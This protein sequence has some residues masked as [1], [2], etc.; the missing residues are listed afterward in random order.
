LNILLVVFIFLEHSLST[1]FLWFQGTTFSALSANHGFSTQIRILISLLVASKILAMLINVGSEQVRE[2]IVNTRVDRRWVSIFPKALMKEDFTKWEEF[3]A[4]I[5][6][7]LP[8]REQLRVSLIFESATVTSLLLISFA[9]VALKGSLT[10]LFALVTLALLTL[11]GHASFDRKISEVNSRIETQRNLVSTWLDGLKQGYRELSKILSTQG[12]NWLPDWFK[13]H[14]SPM[15]ALRERRTKIALRKELFTQATLEWPFVFLMAL[16]LIQ[17]SKGT[18]TIAETVVALGILHYAIRIAQTLKRIQEIKFEETTL[19]RRLDSLLDGFTLSSRSREATVAQQIDTSSA[20][21]SFSFDLRDGTKTSIHLDPG[22]HFVSGYNGSGKSTLIETLA[23]FRRDFDDWDRNQVHGLTIRVSRWID[24]DSTWFDEWGGFAGQVL[25]GNEV[26]KCS[27]D[28]IEIYRRLNKVLSQ[29]LSL[30]WLAVFDQLSNEI[31]IR[32]KRCNWWLSSGERVLMSCLRMLC[33]LDDKVELIF[34]DEVD[35]PLDSKNR[36]LL[37]ESLIELSSR[38]SI[39]YISHNGP[40]TMPPWGVRPIRQTQASLIAL[41]H[42]E[43]ITEGVVI[44]CE[45]H[46]RPGTG[47]VSSIG[48]IADQLVPTFKRVLK[49]CVT[50][51]ADWGALAHFDFELVC[52]RPGSR[53][54]QPES[55]GLAFSIALANV[56]RSHR[57]MPPIANITGTGWVRSNGKIDRVKGQQLKSAACRVLY[58]EMQV[59]LPEDVGSLT[60]IEA[61][62]SERAS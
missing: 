6:Q 46:F 15:S 31:S 38:F 62:L 27:S 22:L 29:R 25:L 59:L 20:G 40:V 32:R 16:I 54:G 5:T 58:P 24:R 7:D 4:A 55:A 43:L 60:N 14:T 23:C 52:S 35:A 13:R 3:K 53:V 12:P 30:R 61:V 51:K 41:A 36:S 1:L 47:K 26:S 44:P 8:R 19:S 50:T 34:A 56:I 9:C 21:R 45:V 37:G 48:N 18:F 57:G 39:H 11:I 28:N 42:K 33:S 49:A 10:L 2:R 17:A